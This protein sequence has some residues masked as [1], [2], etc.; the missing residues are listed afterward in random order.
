MNFLSALRVALGAL[1]VHKGR[2]TLTSLGIVIGISA[3]IAMVSA[4]GGAREKLDERLEN[5]GKNLI[6]IKAGAHTQNGS[7]ADFKPLTNDDAAAVR[8]R[9]SGLVGVAEVQ[10]TQRTASTRTH[11]WSTTVVG[12][13]P[14]MQKV[15]RWEVQYGRYYNPA[16]KASRL[17]PIEALRYE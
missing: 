2:S 10:V 5:V 14:D 12:S 15:R 1:L 11:N 9:V 8:K 17:D 13:S 4:G 16:L 7:L 6:V 3:V